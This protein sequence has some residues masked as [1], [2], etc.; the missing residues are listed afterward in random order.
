[1]QMHEAV[2]KTF[3]QVV[4]GDLTATGFELERRITEELKL[5]GLADNGYFEHYREFAVEMIRYFAT[6]RE[7]KTPEKPAVLRV[8]YGEEEE[9]IVT[10]D[11]VLLASDGS[12][13]LRKIVTGHGRKNDEKKIGAA[14]FLTA[15]HEAF[16]GAEVELVYLADQ[17]TRSVTLKPNELKTRRKHIDKHLGQIKSGRFP[18]KASSRTCPNCPAF[19]ICGPIPNGSITPTF[20]S[21]T[22][23][24]G[25]KS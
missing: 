20:R 24:D 17:R 25:K 15:A 7:G 18:Q 10:H 21:L 1:M 22:N 9:I 3:K 8:A 5:E 16:P 12:R 4:A 11:D 6:S 19:F 14:A 13:T 23:L 2:R